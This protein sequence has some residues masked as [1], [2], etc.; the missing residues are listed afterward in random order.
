MSKPMYNF[1]CVLIFVCIMIVFL[2]NLSQHFF[3]DANKNGEIC[4]ETI[5]FSTF[6]N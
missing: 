6:R 2:T 5:G 4:A 3:M 1:A